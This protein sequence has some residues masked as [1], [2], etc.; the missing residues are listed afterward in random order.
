MHGESKGRFL[1]TDLEWEREK[2]ADYSSDNWE[3][4]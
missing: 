4:E 2:V 3:E 1:C